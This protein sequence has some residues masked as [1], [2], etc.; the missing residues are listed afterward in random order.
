MMARIPKALA[1]FLGDRGKFFPFIEIQDHG[2]ALLF[3]YRS[4][5][6]LQA[7]PEIERPDPMLG[8]DVRIEDRRKRFAITGL[9]FLPFHGAQFSQAAMISQARKPSL[10][11]SFAGIR[12][13]EH[14]S[15]LQSQFHLV[16]RLLLEKKKAN[17]P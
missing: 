12:S 5:R 16:C 11:R 3:I 15:E 13:E 7:L 6:F 4:Q 10:Q 9:P 1:D 17:H 2:P 14:T 8:L